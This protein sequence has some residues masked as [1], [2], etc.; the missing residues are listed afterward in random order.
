LLDLEVSQVRTAHHGN[1]TI[2]TEANSASNSIPV[3][4]RALSTVRDYAPASPIHHTHT[5]TLTIYTTQHSRTLGGH[6]LPCQTRA[7]ASH[8]TPS[9][10]SSTSNPP[11]RLSRSA[12]CGTAAPH[13]QPYHL[14]RATATSCSSLLAPLSPLHAHRQIAA[15][16]DM[17]RRTPTTQTTLLG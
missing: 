13:R 5:H 14:V 16:W 8:C 11:D 6:S 3:S 10:T 4:L 15:H 2:G 17:Y 1:C 7:P 9:A 12:N